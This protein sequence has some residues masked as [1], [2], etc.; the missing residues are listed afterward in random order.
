VSANSA[1][2]T[3]A[4]ARACLVAIILLAAFVRLW[5][6]DTIPPGLWYD[7]AIYALDGLSIGKGNWPVFFTT[8]GHPREPLYIYSLGGF[9]ALFG[10]STLNARIASALWGIATVALFYPFARRAA[11][12]NWALVAVAALAV[13]RWHVHFS[14]TIFRALLPPLFILGVAILF[15][16]WRERR[17]LSDAALC[18]AVMGAGAY[19]YLSFRFVPV[20]LAAWIAWLFARRELTWRSDGRGI[21]MIYAVASIVFVPLGIDY[22]HNPWHFSGRL[23][24]VSMFRKTVETTAPDGSRVKTEVSKTPAEAVRD[25]AGNALDVAKMWTI[26]GD[27]VGKHN[28][29]YA[30][31]F[32]WANGL[33]FYAGI[34][35]CC[36]NLAR[37]EFAFVTVLWLFFMSLTSV[38]S[39]GAPNLLRMQGATPAAILAYVFGLRWLFEAAGRKISLPVRRFGVAALLS[40]FALLQLDTYFRRFPVSPAVHMEF[41]SETFYQPAAAALAASRECGTVFVPEEMALH[42]SFAFVVFGVKNII[43][44]KPGDD[45]PTTGTRPVALLATMRSRELAHAAGK[46]QLAAFAADPGVSRIAS[47]DIPRETPDGTVVKLHW[48]ELM[49]SQIPD[50]RFQTSSSGTQNSEFRIQ[51]S[52]APGSTSGSMTK[53]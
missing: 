36:L 5:R 4:R 29:P 42:P 25:L 9:F 28:L 6:L 14:R 51:N 23:G 21:V 20:I 45:I 26:R 43:P 46:D 13:F 8:E 40:V 19:T 2:L 50:S 1:W 10:H 17:R 35:W 30:P 16:R 39:F 32:D 15:L 7:E 48:G 22:L 44:Y 37:N 49:K 31:V 33:V 24:E 12:R 53:R 18:G 3:P 11:G 47:F 38:F 27:H 41:Q 52:K 34:A